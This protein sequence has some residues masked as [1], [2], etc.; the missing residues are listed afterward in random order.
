MSCQCCYCLSAFIGAAGLYFYL[1]KKT[2]IKTKAEAITKRKA[3]NVNSFQTITPVYQS[4]GPMN[5]LNETFLI[6]LQLN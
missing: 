2:I 1:K 3:K 4:T 6:L 5:S